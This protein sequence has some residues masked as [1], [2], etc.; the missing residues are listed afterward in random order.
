METVLTLTQDVYDDVLTHALDGR[1]AEVCG[2]LGGSYGEERSHAVTARQVENVADS[3]RTTY[4]L[5][6]SEQ[7]EVMDDIEEVGADVVG[8]YHSHPT[9]P[10]RPSPT[11]TAQAT[12]SG[13]S[14]VIVS[15][16]GEHPFVGSWRWTGDRFEREA[17]GI[18][19]G[20]RRLE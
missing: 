7:L 18:S 4:H 1:P 17:V 8:F 3:P 9:G 13:Y 10:P 5:D 6:P 19:S 15:L 12:W 16:S 2:V 11:D 14:Y 20:R